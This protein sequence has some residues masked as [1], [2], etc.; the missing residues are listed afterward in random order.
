[1]DIREI[2]RQNLIALRRQEGT[3]SGIAAKVDTD[4]NYLSQISSGDGKHN[5]G[6]RMARR[7]EKACGKPVGWMDVPHEDD[8]IEQ[9]LSA[10]GRIA[11]RMNQTQRRRL[12]KLMESISDAN[13]APA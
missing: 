3:F 7:L 13:N 4:P 1:M 2:R 12:I 11:R 9:D 10:I 5:M 6:Y 8:E